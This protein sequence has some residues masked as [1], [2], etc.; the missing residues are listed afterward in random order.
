MFVQGF[1]YG[2]SVAGLIWNILFQ[3]VCMYVGSSFVPS[4]LASSI[5]ICATLN[6]ENLFWNRICRITEFLS[7]VAGFYFS[8]VISF[9]GFKDESPVI[10]IQGLM[11]GAYSIMFLFS[12]L[13]RKNQ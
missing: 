13:L 5:F 12:S 9:E 1:R 2:I 10:I 3:L 6:P 7:I 4:I 11:M 8:A